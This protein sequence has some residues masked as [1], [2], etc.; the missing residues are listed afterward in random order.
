MLAEVVFGSSLKP[1]AAAAQAY[2]VAIHGEDLRL[3][4][5]ALNLDG[6]QQLLEFPSEALL[7]RQEKYAAELH[8]QGAGSLSLAPLEN[9]RDA[10]AQDTDHVHADVVLEMAVLDGEHSVL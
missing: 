5:L 3:G 9:V 8:G 6:E 10:S 4:E 7:G 1:V 2:L